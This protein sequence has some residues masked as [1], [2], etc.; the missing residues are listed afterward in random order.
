MYK[1]IGVDG[2]E[3]GPVSAEQ[4]RQW[5]AEGRAHAASPV[6]PEGAP[7]WK[8]LGSLPDFSLLFAAS[9]PARIG[10]LPATPARNV[11]PLAMTGLVMGIVSVTLGLCCCG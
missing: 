5:I 9:A 8:Q 7:E 3:Y 1:I 4:L 11:N 6:L 10:V 2:K